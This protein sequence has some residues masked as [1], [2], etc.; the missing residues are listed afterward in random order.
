[1]RADD[2]TRLKLV[3]HHPPL[4]ERDR[5]RDAKINNALSTVSFF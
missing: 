3:I 2:E 1:M 5:D 4:P